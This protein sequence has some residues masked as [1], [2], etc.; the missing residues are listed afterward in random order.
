MGLWKSR[1]NTQKHWSEQDERELFKLAKAGATMEEALA[2]FP[3]RTHKALV[4]KLNRMGFSVYGGTI[5]VIPE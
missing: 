1:S 4:N 2:S 5:H 3:K